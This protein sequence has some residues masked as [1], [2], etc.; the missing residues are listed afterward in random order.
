MPPLTVGRRPEA[1]IFDFDGVILDSARMKTNAFITLY[2]VTDPAMQ[3]RLRRMVWQN[4][5]LS[6]VKTLAILEQD[7]FGRTPTEESVA[8]LAR[9]YAGMVDTA[10]N[11]CPLIAGAESLLRGLNGTPCHLV[12]GTPHDTLMGTVRAKGLEHFFVTITGSPSRKAEVFAKIVATGNHDPAQTLAVGDSLTELDA[13]RQVGTA[14]VGVVAEDLAN[15]FPAD[16]RIVKDM[17]GLAEL[18]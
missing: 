10:V 18:I 1:I 5:G 16:V 7:L 14:F 9:R 6:R 13:S 8:D 11:D 17:F 15:P 2:G 4:G 3:D 12:S